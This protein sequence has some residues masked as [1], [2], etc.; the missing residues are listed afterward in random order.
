V[1]G[2]GSI[3]SRHARALEA[4]GSE[5]ALVTM[6]EDCGNAR[7]FRSIGDGIRE[8]KPTYCLIT[9]ETARHL[10]VFEELARLGFSGVLFVEK[11]L[12]DGMRTLPAN[13]FGVILVGYHLRVHPVI[14]FLNEYLA[15]EKICSAQCYVGQYL[16]DWRPGRDYRK[17][18]SAS[19]SLGGGVTKDLSHE[20]DYLIYLLGRWNRVAAIE[21]RFSA[22]EIE[23]E[24]CCCILGEFE[25]CPVAT[26]Q[27]NYL[28][29]RKRRELLINTARDTVRADLIESTVTSEVRGVLLDRPGVDLYEN[30]HDEILNQ[31][32]E[33]LTTAVEGI[34]VMRMIDCIQRASETR[35]WIRN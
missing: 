10:G 24:D 19:K 29:R 11:P 1:I 7:V 2:Y 35:E 12:F 25:R 13:Q 23:T 4:L 17:Q 34:E 15:G 30:L 27:L 26:V 14:R 9:N 3:G 16:P 8:Y 33:G 5:V 20:L 28:D 32:Y 31:R 6:R 21:G 22:L 18:Y